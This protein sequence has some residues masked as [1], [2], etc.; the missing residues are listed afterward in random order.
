MDMQTIVQEINTLKERITKHYQQRESTAINEVALNLAK[1]QG[2]MEA[3]TKN[4][5]NPFFKSTYASFADIVRC[6]RPALAKYGLSVIQIIFFDEERNMTLETRLMHA[7]GQWISSF[8]P[9]TPPKDDPQGRGSYITY[10]KRY[11]YA[12]LVGVYTEDEDDDGEKAMHSAAKQESSG[13][14]TKKNYE[15]INTE[16]VKNIMFEI[17]EH[18]DIARYLLRQFNIEKLAEIPKEYYLRVIEKI[19]ANVRSRNEKK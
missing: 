11:A 6:S 8:M 18:D 4:N 10:M 7:S 13:R 12:A 9:I 15:K 14:Y 3:A 19:R 2:E 16:Q 5:V 1:A 17:G